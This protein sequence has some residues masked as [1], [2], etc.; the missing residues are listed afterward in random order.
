MKKQVFIYRYYKI[1]NKKKSI[2]ISL[3]INNNKNY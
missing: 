3:K 2:I 1:I